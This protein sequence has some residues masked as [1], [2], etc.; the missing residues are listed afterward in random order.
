MNATLMLEKTVQNFPARTALVSGERRISYAE[1]DATTNKLANALARIG[2]RKGDR[3]ALLI[4]N[5]PEFV[6]GYF[7]I[8]KLGAVVVALDTRY[9][10]G[11]LAAVMA[12]CQPRVL[13]GEN[14]CLEPVATGMSRFP[15]LEKIISLTP[16][17][18]GRFLSFTDILARSPATRPSAAIDSEDLAMIS[19]SGGPTSHPK[20]AAITHK[21]LCALAT[22]SGIGFE[23]TQND[24]IMLFALPMYHNFALGSVLLTSVSLGSA[25]VVVPGTG[26]SINSLLE[27]IQKEKGTMWLGVPYIYA[28]AVKIAEEEGIKSD[29]SSLRLVASGGAPLPVSTILKF[30]EYFHLPLLDVWGLTEAVS[31]V[32]C[33]PVDG[34][35]KLGSCGKPIPG[36]AVRIVDDNGKELPANHD[37]EIIVHGPM[38]ER[39]YNN[40]EDTA[41]AIRN[42]WL[43]TGDIGKMDEDGF[44]YITGRKKRMIILKG[45]NVYPHDIEE[46]LLT[47]P[48]VA[49]AKV[50]GAADKLRGEV[51][52]A[53]IRLKEGQEASEQEIKQF[54]QRIMAD[55]KVPKQVIFTRYPART[56]AGN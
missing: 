55:Y 36:Y 10:A 34:S 1:L 12:N 18:A 39:Y 6:F 20:G 23:Q 31:H 41:K 56:G 47:H 40:P 3:V 11:E 19:Y 14:P 7:G 17:A 51:V 38:M 28:L 54:C 9:K 37:G 32:T 27:T 21:N 13:I 25:I 16:D 35:G 53:I 29:L 22:A 2:I 5:S 50:V 43:Y 4:S 45:Q 15:S 44:V 48:K 24:I 42:G 33:P 8:L 52:S 26:V 49:E 30:K 46:V